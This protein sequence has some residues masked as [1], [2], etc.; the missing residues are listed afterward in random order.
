MAQK[1]LWQP[2]LSWTDK[3]NTPNIEKTNL[4]NYGRETLTPA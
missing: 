2:C 1:L 3:K 4:P